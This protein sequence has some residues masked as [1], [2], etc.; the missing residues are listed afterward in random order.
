MA[1]GFKEVVFNTLEEVI[2]PDLNRAQKFKGADVAEMMRYLINVSGGT[3]DLDSGGIA[4]EYASLESPLRAEIINGFQ[5]HPTI[6]D[7]RFSI[8]PGVLFALNPDG[9]PDDSNYKYVHDFGAPLSSALTIATNSS[10]SARVDIIGATVNF[11]TPEV[12]SRNLFNPTTGLFTPSAISKAAAGAL[13]YSVVQGTPGSGL[14]VVPAGFLPLCV[15]Y[16]PNGSVNNDACSFYD[17]R[18]LV[19]DRAYGLSNLGTFTSRLL[20]SDY[21]IDVIS[22]PTHAWMSGLSEAVLN[23]RRVGG[24]LQS[25]SPV[26]TQTVPTALGQTYGIDLSD[27]HN[28]ELGYTGVTSGISFLYF[29][30]PGGLPRWARYTPA[31]SGVRKPAGPRGIVTMSNKAPSNPITGAPPSAITV[32]G[33]N[34]AT[35]NAVC[36]GIIGYNS[37]VAISPTLMVDKKV[38]VDQAAVLPFVSYTG[39][40]TGQVVQFSLNLGSTPVPANARSIIV[41]FSMQIA[42]T[43]GSNAYVSMTRQIIVSDNSNSRVASF[44]DGS[45]QVIMPTANTYP[46]YY[47]VEIPL[48]YLFPS[49]S[50]SPPGAFLNWYIAAGVGNG[51]N[52]TT[53]VA[54][55]FIATIKGYRLA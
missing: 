8:D 55:N 21:F 43:S 38:W 3:D 25:G 47:E 46:F 53:I 41:V 15:A 26:A 50:G 42:N 10:G 29:V 22:V 2:S 33:L 44:N 1:S 52:G 31:S 34:A 6:G 14:P 27:A 48:P 20:R 4:T 9:A 40:G 23:G 35:L 45:A 39:S 37:S 16:V 51:T 11:A 24:I 49:T 30:L 19:S 54:S 12:D 28:A 17:V 32:Q 18:P 7:I 13:T 36:F 5:V